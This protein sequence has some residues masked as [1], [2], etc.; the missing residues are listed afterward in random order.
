MSDDI[1]MNQQVVRGKR[2]DLNTQRAKIDSLLM[3]ESRMPQNARTYLEG[4]LDGLHSGIDAME[5]VENVQDY[6][7]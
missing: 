1:P 3:N 4:Y 5:S 7:R 6:D 2:S